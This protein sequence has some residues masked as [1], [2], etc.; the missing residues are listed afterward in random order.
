MLRG[1]IEK[2]SRKGDG[3]N[4]LREGINF[5]PSGSEAGALWTDGERSLGVECPTS[6][7]T[8]CDR[9]MNSVCII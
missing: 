9:E 1:K 6:E 2:G 3:A 4:S 8:P 5:P 7:Q